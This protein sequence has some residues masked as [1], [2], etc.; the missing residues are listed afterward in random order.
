MR[1][2]PT[3]NLSTAEMATGQNP[4]ISV[5]SAPDHPPPV[6][7]Y[8][9]RW[10]QRTYQATQTATLTATGGVAFNSNMFGIPGNFYV[11]KVQIWKLTQN[12]GPG[13]MGF[14]Y[15]NTTTDLG[16]DTVVSTDYGTATSLAGMTFKVPLGHAKLVTASSS[17]ALVDCNPAIIKPAPYGL[18]SYVCHLHCWVSI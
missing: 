8:G 15:Q 10:V 2:Y 12:S 6:T 16:G 11:D 18:D 4:S 3:S 17:T 9:E 7:I 13:I 5:G 14:F 1:S